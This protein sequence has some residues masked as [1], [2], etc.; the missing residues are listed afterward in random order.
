MNFIIE[1]NK[2]GQVLHDFSFHLIQAISF[3]NWKYEEAQHTFTL[4]NGESV[5]DDTSIPVGSLR[6]VMSSINNRVEKATPL[7]IPE[8][9]SAERFLKR[10][11]K[12][13]IL[14]EEIARMV[15]PLFIKSSDR[16]KEITDI[17]ESE[18]DILNLPEGR[19]DVSEVV[20]ILHEWRVFVHQDRIVGVKH[21]SGD[22]VFPVSPDEEVVKQMVEV[23]EKG[24]YKGE[25]FPL[26]YTLD[27]GINDRGTFL[28][29]A[30]P[31]VSCGLYGFAD[32][33]V[34]PSMF[35]QGYRYMQ[36]QAGLL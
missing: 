16:Y 29:E 10:E 17:Y 21:Y 14:K 30:H 35:I 32:Y 9:L 2:D 36:M 5:S 6:F 13:G 8:K 33:Q 34:L 18:V 3:H 24:R 22:S 19:Y 15:L 26:S 7:N 31:F 27:V 20:D 25:P 1:S 11:M 4:S 23:I 28:I 12:K